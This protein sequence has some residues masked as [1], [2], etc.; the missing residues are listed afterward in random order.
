MWL[1]HHFVAKLRASSSSQTSESAESAESLTGAG[2]LRP[3]V[4]LASFP[5]ILNME[6]DDLK[7]RFP[8]KV[9]DWVTRQ[10]ARRLEALAKKNNRKKERKLQFEKQLAKQNAAGNAGGVRSFST[11]SRSTANAAGAEAADSN[12]DKPRRSKKAKIE[13]IC[14]QFR[15]NGMCRWGSKCIFPHTHE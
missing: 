13:R 3:F 8:P 2:A 9:L 7:T 10:Q 14:F 12:H 4:G 11:V 15:S 1:V 6:E 5:E